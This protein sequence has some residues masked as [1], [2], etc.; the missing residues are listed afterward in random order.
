MEAD[1]SWGG[2]ISLFKALLFVSAVI[3]SDGRR[4]NLGCSCGLVFA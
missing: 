1:L 3:S 2:Y 4:G